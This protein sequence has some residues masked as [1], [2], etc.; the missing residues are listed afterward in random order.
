MPK[1]KCLVQAFSMDDQHPISNLH[2]FLEN[3]PE[4][5]LRQRMAIQIVLQGERLAPKS[6]HWWLSELQFEKLLY[7]LPDCAL[8]WKNKGFFSLSSKN[9]KFRFV[10]EGDFLR[11]QV[12]D[13][14]G[15][16]IAVHKLLGSEKVFVVDS[17][18]QVYGLESV[19]LPEEAMALLQEIQLPIHAL[20]ESENAAVFF[21][22]VRR[23]INAEKLVSLARETTPEVSIVVRA[24]V[25]GRLGGTWLLRVH[26]VTQLHFKSQEHELEVPSTGDLCALFPFLD[27]EQLHWVLRPVQ[28]EEEARNALFALGLS[29][30]QT[31]NGFECQGARA[32]SVL[33]QLIHKN[34]L[35]AFVKIDQDVLPNWV[36]LPSLLPLQAKESEDRASVEVSYAMGELSFSIDA[37]IKAHHDQEHAIV[38][39]DQS[40]VTFEPET[41]EALERLR[42]LLGLTE[43]NSKKQIPWNEAMLL[44]SML[45]SK[46]ELQCSKELQARLKTFIPELLPQDHAL[47]NA[48]QTLLRPYQRDG[49]A[50]MSQ[51]HRSGFGYLLADDMGLGKT[52]MVLTLLAKLKEQEGPQT[53][54]VVCPTSVMD[55]W[56]MEAQKHIPTLEVV[57]WHGTERQS[58]K[59]AVLKADV[60]V[61]TYGLLRRDVSEFLSHM[62]FRYVVLDEAQQVKNPRTETWKS[63]RLLNAK[64]RLALTGTPIENRVSD[65]WSIFEILQPSILGSERGFY[66]RY[67]EPMGQGQQEQA[68]ELKERIRPLVLRR[69]KNDVERD[70]PPKIE[71][72]LYC[73]MEPDQ[74]ELYAQILAMVGKEFKQQLEAHGDARLSISLL[75]ALTR[76]R[77]VCCDPRLVLKSSTPSVS[78]SKL[79]TL[80]ETLKDCLAMGRKVIIYSQFVQMQKWI[81]VL[82][83][84]MGITDALWLHGATRNRHEVVSKFQAEDGPRV[85]VVS[86]KAGGVG[87]TLTAADTVILYDPWWNPAV[88][89]QAIDR[90]HRIG[91]T[92][93]V[94]VIRLLCPN[95]I[96]EQIAD[97]CK[98]KRSHSQSVLTVDTT[99]K[100][101]I[102]LE[103][104]KQILNHA[105]MAKAT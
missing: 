34:H 22:L 64:S 88:E 15:G 42:D 18:L 39:D 59:E 101:G 72:I 78:S 5:S 52:L 70:L 8:E 35:P 99:L 68:K 26:L 6:D 105:L 103:E 75:A 38:L 20:K 61:T 98:K 67:V 66:K 44:F 28:Q 73:E 2:V 14:L 31:H 104:I 51:M 92:K 83:Q 86:L 63:A 94:H 91:Q 27:G 46:V 100:G 45:S 32:L 16:P 36:R 56:V 9:A 60:V 43:S 47:P 29:P 69:T 93:T 89:D 11:V 4:L 71:N 30:S 49:V 84:E 77:Q 87:I 48:L 95:T 58:Q 41:V 40:I 53:S 25:Q 12:V 23:G 57:K 96:E 80:R 76:L 19:F 81:H 62:A 24:L 85:I 65:L 79:S 54:L 74:K 90:A 21:D 13:T 55:V 17:H 33:S 1:S 102:T 50:W 10:L 3:T 37:L 82:L 97:L 7:L